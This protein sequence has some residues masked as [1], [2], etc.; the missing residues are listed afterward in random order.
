MS[1]SGNGWIAIGPAPILGGQIGSTGFTRPMSGRIADVAVDPSNASRWLVGAAQGGIWQTMDAGTTWSP[2]T[3]G[4]ASLAMGAIAFAP[5]DPSV[6]YAG[7]GEATFSGVSYHGAGLLKSI[8]GGATWSLLAA[9]TLANLSFSD[10]KVNPSDP[11]IVLAATAV[12]FAGRQGSPPPLIPPRGVYRSADGGASWSLVLSGHATDLETDPA[13]FDRQY[14]GIGRIFGSSAV[15]ANGVYRSTNGGSSWTAVGGPWT[16]LPSGVGRV[17]LAIAPS[18]SNVL[19]VSIQDAFDSVG[20]DGGLLGLWRSSDAWSPTPTWTP[21]PTGAI[22]D[23]TGTHGYCGWD[24]AFASAPDQCWYDHEIVADP[25]DANVLYA[26]G[27]ALWRYDGATWIEVSQTASSPFDGIH[28]DQHSMAWAGGRLIVGNDG[29][30]WSTTDGG[31]TW[32]DH[33]AGLAI[34]QFYDGAIHPTDPDFALGGSQDNGTEKW[35]G[36]AAW[37]WVFGG[38]GSDSVIASV[39]PNTHWAVSAQGLVILRTRNGGASFTLAVSGIDLTNAPFI[40]RFEKCPANDDVL[41]AGTDNLWK[42]TDFFSAGVPTWASNGPEMAADLSALDFAASDT[43]CHSYAY[44]T[45]TGALRLTVDAGA[46]WTDI[47][48]GNSVA[49]RAVTDLAFD[50]SNA[51]V[52]YV[53]LSGFDEGTPEQPGHLFKTANATSGAPTW[54]DVSPPVNIPFNTVALDPF[55]PD[56][57]YAGTDIGVWRSADGGGTWTHMGPA[58]GMPNVAVFDLQINHATGRLVAFT[59]GR[60]AFVLATVGICPGGIGPDMDADGVG[61]ACDNCPSVPDPSQSDSDGDAIGDPCDCAPMTPGTPVPGPLGNT[62]MVG[63]DPGSG[64]TMVTWTAIPVATHYNAYI[65]T[66]P[67]NGM[68]SRPSPY[69]HVCLESDDAMGDGPTLSTVS[70]LPAAGTAFY[71]PITGENGCG[72]G[73]SGEAL[74]PIPTP[75][76]NP[77]PCPTPP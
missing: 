47:D 66:I 22:D 16:G 38:D 10:L 44:G 34:T 37:N 14:A 1:V 9:A 54:T 61:D 46:L 72:E 75:R 43:A 27:L 40:A 36:S 20:A 8:D 6:I 51:S 74:N 59:H 7:T 32:L 4:Q 63:H 17:E 49:D 35:T 3:D 55:D 56:I 64:L 52:L 73:S 24:P 76:P 13:D 18:N 31:A 26:G 62:V 12:G 33:N 48:P 67:P 58:T 77:S 19:Y 25:A 71:F 42:S 60:G 29:G 50:P 70:G 39:N 30:V 2:L 11:G 45:D 21:I 23:G 15:S 28:V 53:T 68:G 5:S 65:G 57:V 41:I 69:D